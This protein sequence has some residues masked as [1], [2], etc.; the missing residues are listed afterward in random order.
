MKNFVKQL[1]P[2]LRKKPNLGRG[3]FLSQSAIVPGNQKPGRQF[4]KVFFVA[5]FPVPAF[6]TRRPAA[7]CHKLG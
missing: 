5:K 3:V 2:F 6:L 4:R 1:D 7:K